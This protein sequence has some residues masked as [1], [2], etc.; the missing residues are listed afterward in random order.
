MAGALLEQTEKLLEHDDHP[1]RVALE[2][3]PNK[4]EFCLNEFEPLIQTCV[5]TLSSKI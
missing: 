2:H 1:I 4:F 3:T 5:T